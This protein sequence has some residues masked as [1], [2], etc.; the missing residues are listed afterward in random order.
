MEKF[1]TDYK[2]V[3]RT[4]QRLQ[5]YDQIQNNASVP[6]MRSKKSISAV[7]S[8]EKTVLPVIQLQTSVPTL[9]FQ[10]Q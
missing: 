7:A 8:K 6:L 3:M 5:D 2:K 1:E 10:Y 4:G 9:N